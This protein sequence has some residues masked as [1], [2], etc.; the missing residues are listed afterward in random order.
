M[1]LLPDDAK[2]IATTGSLAAIALGGLWKLY[3]MFRKDARADRSEEETYGQYRK[4]LDQKDKDIERRDREIE[5]LN[6]V[7]NILSTRLDAE[8]E[9]RRRLSNE[10]LEQTKPPHRPR[11]VKRDPGEDG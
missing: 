1:P 9:N 4:L 2:D 8:M 7:N 5:R 3:L 10:L 11:V 6:A